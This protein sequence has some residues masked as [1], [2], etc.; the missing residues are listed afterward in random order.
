MLKAALTPHITDYSLEVKYA[1]AQE[2]SDTDDDFEIIEK[3]TDSL[4]VDLKLQDKE[5][6]KEA[7]EVS[8]Q[9]PQ[10]IRTYS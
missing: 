7:E 8:N 6:G 2:K 10:L 1:E 4:R 9:R 5:P 3:V